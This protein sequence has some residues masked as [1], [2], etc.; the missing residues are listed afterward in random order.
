MTDAEY[1]SQ[2]ERLNRAGAH[3][4][5]I[6]SLNEFAREMRRLDQNQSLFGL[7]NGK[8]LQIPTAALQPAVLDWI[9]VEVQKH[10]DALAKL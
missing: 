9:T 1:A 8:Q 5:S 4:A 10:K 3:I 7:S 6:S 2:C